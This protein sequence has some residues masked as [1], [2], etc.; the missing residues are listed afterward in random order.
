MF[1]D[2]Y[3]QKSLVQRALIKLRYLG[4]MILKRFDFPFLNNFNDQFTNDDVNIKITLLL[5]TVFL[6]SSKSIDGSI[7]S[8]SNS[9]PLK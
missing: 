5:S 6:K 7:S 4:G 3:K 9:F 8:A 1:L 2:L